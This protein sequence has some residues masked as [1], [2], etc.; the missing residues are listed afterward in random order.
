MSDRLARLTLM[1]LAEPGDTVMGALVALRG[2]EAAVAL[3][4]AGAA[5]A[6]LVRWFAGTHGRPPGGPGRSSGDRKSVV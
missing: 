1:R 5:D 3:V 2:P 6:D 4:R